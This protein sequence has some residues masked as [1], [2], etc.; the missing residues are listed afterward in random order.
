MGTSS[1]LLPEPEAIAEYL[2]A[3]LGTPSEVLGPELWVLYKLKQAARRSG[4][5]LAVPLYNLEG[6]E[7]VELGWMAIG[8]RMAVAIGGTMVRDPN[9]REKVGF[10][11]TDELLMDAAQETLNIV[12]VAFNQKL[13]TL[14]WHSGIRTGTMEM[15]SPEELDRQVLR[16]GEGVLSGLYILRFPKLNL[17]SWTKRLG[18][19]GIAFHCDP[20]QGPRPLIMRSGDE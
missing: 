20:E 5:V 9:L 13:E 6:E 18:S 10:N 8:I 11:Q 19:L 15:L 1:D 16:T 7:A 3:S 4:G 2:S 14:G 17:P 12:S